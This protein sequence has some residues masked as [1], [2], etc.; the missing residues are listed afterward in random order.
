MIVQVW[1]SLEA[2]RDASS[3]PSVV[4]IGTFDGVHRGHRVVVGHG[5]SQADSRGLPLTVLTFDPHPMAVVR[6]GHQPPAI[7]TLR[8]R[9]ELLGQAGADGVLVLPFDTDVAAMTAEDFVQ[10]VLVDAIGAAVVVVGEDFRFGNRAAGDVGLLRRMGAD[11][12][13]GVVAVAAVGHDGIRWSSTEV[14]ARVAAGDMRGASAVLGH[15]FEVEG[16][17]VVG[18]SR[19]RDLGYPTANVAVGAGML[20]PAD[21]VYA[22]YLRRL[23]DPTTVLPAA[24]SVGT[25][26]TFDGMERRVEAYVLGV[27]DIDLY[28][29]PVAVSFVEQLRGQRRFADVG[30]LVA[31]MSADVAQVDA[32]LAEHSPSEVSSLLGS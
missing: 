21:G 5:R 29:Q 14:R 4:S 27:D 23:A 7:A 18:D 28:D 10:A 8:H 26:P 19:G 25:N 1:H 31:Q 2:A 16:L 11:C 13:F 6:P 17:V 9:V 20:V 15:L 30:E 24:V 3:G 22:G 32:L 12:G